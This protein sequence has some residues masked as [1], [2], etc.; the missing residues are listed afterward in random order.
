MDKKTF[1]ST[2]IVNENNVASSPYMGSGDIDVFATPA[3]VA[4]MENAA[5][6]CVADELPEGFSTVGISINTTHEKATPLGDTVTATAELIAIDGRKLSFKI[7]ATDSK[8]KIGEGVH[9]RFIID[10]AKFMMKIK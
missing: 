1:S 7:T 5:M 6:L 9:E 2:T 10:K 4:L 3:M 8:G